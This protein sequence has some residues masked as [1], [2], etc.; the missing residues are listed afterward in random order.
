MQIN[1]KSAIDYFSRNPRTLFL[2][3]GLGAV[4][5]TFS[6]F[7]VLRN[8]YDYFGIP[9]NILTYLSVIGLV[10]CAYS[11]ACYCL[12]KDYW[13]PYL[14]IIGISNFLY[15]ILTTMLLYAYYKGLTRIGLTYFLAE[16]LIIMLLVY[17]ELRVANMLRTQ[18]TN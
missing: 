10:Y 5:T 11:M 16:I 1:I 13:T 7:F 18:K 4:L 3:D 15:C 9:A 17:I 8:Y 6:L 2:L 12:L 14:R